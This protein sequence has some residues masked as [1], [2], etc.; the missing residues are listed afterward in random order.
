MF[1]ASE[2]RKARLACDVPG[3]PGPGD[4]FLS[5]ITPGLGHFLVLAVISGL[6]LLRHELIWLWARAPH[7]FLNHRVPRK[8][9]FDRPVSGYVGVQ[10]NFHLGGHFPDARAQV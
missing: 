7:H 1:C 4:R 5:V 8:R 2:T 3:P 10:D 9:G 6:E